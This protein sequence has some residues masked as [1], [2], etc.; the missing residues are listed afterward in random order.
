MLGLCVVIVAA[1]FAG[2][3]SADPFV[4]PPICSSAGMA[5]SGNYN[6]ITLSGNAYVPE[7]ATLNVRGNLRLTA[8]SCLD[9][10][11]LSTVHVHGNIL[12]GAHAVLGLGCTPGS[13]GPVPPCREQTTADTVDGSVIA[14]EALTM[15]LDGDTIHGDVV[16]TGGGPG[17]TLNPYINFP[18]KD[19]TIGGNL[20]VSG[21][22]GAW[23]G[24]VRNVVGG[25][26]VLVKNV[27]LTAP[28]GVPDSTEVAT[29][30]IA[31]DLIC[32]DNSPTAQ[33]GDSGGTINTVGGAK[34]GQCKAV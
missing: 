11:S 18:I 15:Y 23:F 26:V 9:A 10:F 3:A 8:G 22:Q 12:V 27:G 24:V 17:P 14:H 29:N 19:N 7:G 1:V 2:T 32:L 28:E 21:W 33:I 16:S 13:I 31:G 30:T 34:V 25:K 5:L 20:M 4:G 6:E